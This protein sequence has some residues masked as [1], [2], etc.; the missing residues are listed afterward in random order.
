[1]KSRIIAI[2][3]FVAGTLAF[4]VNNVT[5]ATDPAIEKQYRKTQ[6]DLKCAQIP[7]PNQIS[8]YQKYLKDA[9]KYRDLL[10][11][12]GFTDPDDARNKW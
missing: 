5:A 2:V 3:F 11:K 9:K 10:N 4:C 7:G 6:E 12:A 8:C 1:M